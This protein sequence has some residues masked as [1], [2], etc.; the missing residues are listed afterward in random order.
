MR[1][2]ILF[3]VFS[4]AWFSASAQVT[5]ST[6][7]KWTISAEFA[8]NWGIHGTIQGNSTQLNDDGNIISQRSIGQSFGGG[9]SPGIG[10]DYRLT[11]NLAIG[12]GAAYFMGQTFVTEEVVGNDTPFRAEAKMRAPRVSPRVTFYSQ[13]SPKIQLFARA[14]LDFV[15][16]P[17][18][19]ETSSGPL[20]VPLPFDFD[21]D[22]FPI[23]L[24]D[25]FPELND[26][27]TES[28]TTG[29]CNP[30]AVLQ[31]GLD[32]QLN[33]RLSIQLALDYRG[34]TFVADKGTSEISGLGFLDGLINVPYLN[35]VNYTD[36]L[37]ATSNNIE[38]N[39]TNPDFN[40]P[41]EELE[42]RSGAS[43]LGLR[44]GLAVNF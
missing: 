37:T 31:L 18:I 5:E 17:V 34:Y 39:T 24:G 27:Q 21:T 28:R 41:R 32:Y 14:G 1:A 42:F 22:L 43:S 9:I 16:R 33:Q 7:N 10:I 8:Y 23:D 11:K 4:G 6:F 36:E 13:I 29:R 25:F 44:V 38:F 3:I 19:E 26:I 35:E 30:G 12:I 20:D 2:T 40:A 15:M